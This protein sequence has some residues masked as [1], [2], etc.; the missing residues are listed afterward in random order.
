MKTAK[1]EGRLFPWWHPCK[2]T[3]SVKLFISRTVVMWETETPY[4]SN[5]CHPQHT[6]VCTFAHTHTYTHPKIKRNF[7]LQTERHTMSNKKVIRTTTI[8]IYSGKVIKFQ[9]WRIKYK[10]SRK[11]YL[12]RKKKLGKGW[13]RIQLMSGFSTVTK[14]YLSIKFREEKKCDPRTLYSVKALLRI[15]Y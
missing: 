9:G 7:N 3:S 10:V 11:N 5:N 15:I 13:E 8:K 12:N 6:H 1:E 2:P 14:G 4:F